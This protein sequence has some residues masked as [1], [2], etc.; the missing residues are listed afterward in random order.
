[1]G[2][3][4]LCKPEFENSWTDILATK[5]SDLAK[6]ERVEQSACTVNYGTE[7]MKIDGLSERLVYGEKVCIKYDSGFVVLF[8]WRV[9]ENCNRELL[10]IRMEN[11][12][13]TNKKKHKAVLAKITEVLGEMAIEP[14]IPD[15]EL[16]KALFWTFKRKA[17]LF[18][19]LF[20]IT[21]IVVTIL[22]FIV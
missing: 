7:T 21:L 14:Q 3:C 19:I 20:S 1:M 10:L 15:P 9:P 2:E 8:G 13:T 5:I 16:R 17:I 11:Q 22:V 6:V 18:L 4:F 12:R